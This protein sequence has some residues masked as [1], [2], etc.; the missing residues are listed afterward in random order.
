MKKILF[1]PLMA[2][3]LALCPATALS[4]DVG[5]SNVVVDPASMGEAALVLPEKALPV[6]GEEVPPNVESPASDPVPAPPEKVDTTEEAAQAVSTLLAA[7]ESGQWALFA[8][9]LVMLLVWFLNGVAKLK[10]HIPKK[11][12]PWVAAVLGI[13][14]S[15]A[16]ALISGD[17]PLT[18]ALVQGF[19]GGA[20]SVGLWEMFLQNHK[21]TKEGESA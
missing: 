6:V 18:Q 9:V 17:I 2:L 21:K 5:P 11:A 1:V 7:A 20:T 3:F 12:V 4:Q 19:L 8:G 13:L 14:G 10:E 16:A 15:V